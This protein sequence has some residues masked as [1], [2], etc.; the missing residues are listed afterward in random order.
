MPITLRN[1]VGRKPVRREI[2][3]SVR[4]ICIE[5]SI[6]RRIN[7]GEMEL[8]RVFVLNRNFE[9]ILFSYRGVERSNG[10]GRG[11]RLTG[12]K[13]VGEMSRRKAR[14]TW[15]LIVGRARFDS[16]GDG[17]NA[18]ASQFDFLRIYF[19]QF[20]IPIRFDSFVRRDPIFSYGSMRREPVRT[21]RYLLVV[22]S[23]QGYP[24][25]PLTIV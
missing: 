4:T 1:K 21:S 24:S 9:M 8:I 25:R 15:Q 5:I 12:E 18:I 10:N 11:K 6:K 16:S 20:F 23:R 7:R 22:V 13:N 3:S 19:C 14:S 17:K 2:S